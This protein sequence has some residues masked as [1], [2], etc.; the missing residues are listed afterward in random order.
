MRVTTEVKQ[1]CE[2]EITR[3]M[4]IAEAKYPTTTFRQPTLTYRLKGRTAGTANPQTWE[5]R[6]NAILLMENVKH[7]VEDTV[8]HEF[9]HLVDYAVH[10][11]QYGSVNWRTGR[12]KR[13]HH[14]HTFKTIMRQFGRSTSTTHNMDT[15][16]A[17]M[18]TG[19]TTKIHIWKCGC[20]VGKVTIGAKRHA[21]MLKVAHT[22]FGVYQ[23]GHTA[24]RCGNYSY[25][26]TTADELKPMPLP[27]AA[28]TKTPRVTRATGLTKLDLCRKVYDPELSRAANI[29]AFTEE[30]C[31]PAGAATYYAKIK[32]EF[33]A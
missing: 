2:A 12:R 32:K 23:R 21:R 19:R 17:S 4:A 18:S 7:M 28:K 22:G 15:S 30:G 31:T 5:I 27:V 20:G 8:S 16:N 3:C 13:I 11:Q 24:K 26:G 1:M 14:G 10:G 29:V 25:F 9:A 6:I 33:G